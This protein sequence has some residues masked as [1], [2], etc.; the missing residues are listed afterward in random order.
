[1]N[2]NRSSAVYRF[3]IKPN[4]ANDPRS[5]GYLEDAHAL[6]I[7]QVQEIKCFDLYFLRGD[8]SEKDVK[9]LADHLLHNPV[10]QTVET[11]LLETTHNQNNRKE[12]L[13]PSSRVIEVALRAG[14]TDPVAEQITRAARLI[15]VTNLNAA[16]TGLRFV[17]KGENLT[18]ALL[19]QLAKRLLANA[20]IQYYN[21]GEILPSFSE[22]KPANGQVG[23]FDFAAMDDKALLN[24]ST[25]R[26]AALNL[27]EMRCIKDYCLKEKRS[28]TDIE[29][30]MLAQT[31]SEHCVHKTFK[32][33]VS[34]EQSG[35]YPRTLPTEY[36]HLFS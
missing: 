20:V 10:T 7:H 21:L 27:A 33:R 6:G 28:I 3:V 4:S 35:A 15:G 8:L 22:S 34:V 12:I 11:T 13:L 30:E 14:V 2:L 5:S 29:F 25:E 36:T 9:I 18:D 24:L 17:V 16:S 32:S 19:E 23:T 1:M 26:R 31:W